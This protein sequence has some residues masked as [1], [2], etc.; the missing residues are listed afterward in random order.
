MYYNP[1]I[2]HRRSIRLAGFDYSREA[3]YY[4]TL[5]CEDRASLFGEIIDR[6]MFLSTPGKIAQACW[7]EI[8]DH[9]PN[10][11]LHDF[12]IMPNHVHGIVELNND[13]EHDLKELKYRKGSYPEIPQRHAFQ[14]LI[15]RSI[16][17]IVKGFKIGVTKWMRANTEIHVVWQRDYYEHI[18]RD[19]E[20]YRRISDYIQDNPANWEKDRFRRG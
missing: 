3:L 4:V 7:L 2:H 10:A 19:E 14:R 12:I 13:A 5:C 20:D 17:S 18:I 6:Q 11:V 8:P 16:G 9:F 1:N 15:P